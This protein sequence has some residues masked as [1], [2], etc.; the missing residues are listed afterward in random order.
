MTIQFGEKISFDDLIEE[1]EKKHG[2]LW[3]FKASVQEETSDDVDAWISKEE[4]KEL[5]SKIVRRIET[6]LTKLNNDDSRKLQ[7]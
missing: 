1:H 7:S 3:K 6:A 5:Y 2:P 4:D